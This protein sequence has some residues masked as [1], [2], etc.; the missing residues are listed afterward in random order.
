MYKTAL[1][2]LTAPSSARTKERQSDKNKR[3]YVNPFSEALHRTVPDYKTLG[4]FVAEPC[5][6]NKPCLFIP[7]TGK[8]IDII[9]ELKRR[10]IDFS[11]QAHLWDTNTQFP[12][13]LDLKYFED[14]DYAPL[15]PEKMIS[16][17]K[18]VPPQVLRFYKD[19]VL[20][21]YVTDISFDSKTRLYS[22]RFK[23]G[24]TTN[25]SPLFVLFPFDDPMYFVDRIERAFQLRRLEESW[26]RYWLFIS[27]VPREDIQILTPQERSRF[28]S[29]STK[30]PKFKGFKKDGE[31][32]QF[33]LKILDEIDSQMQI[34][35]NSIIFNMR[36]LTN[37]TLYR[38]LSLPLPRLPGSLQE[39][40]HP[41]VEG[42][43]KMTD[44]IKVI[45]NIHLFTNDWFVNAAPIIVS[46][47]LDISSSCLFNTICPQ[48]LPLEQWQRHHRNYEK[49]MISKARL[50]FVSQL[51]TVIFDVIRNIKP[52]YSLTEFNK[53]IYLESPLGRFVGLC[54]QIIQ[55]H[56][57]DFIENSISCFKENIKEKNPEEVTVVDYKF[58]KNSFPDMNDHPNPM[59]V[60]NLEVVDGQVQFN[61]PIEY[62]TNAFNE[63][64]EYCI[65][66]FEDFQKIE[67]SVLKAM[68]WNPVPV[69]VLPDM[70]SPLVVDLKN[71][72][73]EMIDESTKHMTEYIEKLS[74]FDDILTVSADDFAARLK[75]SEDDLDKVKAA[76]A[77]VQKQQ[78]G[79][80]ID[81]PFKT[82]I[83]LFEV[84]LSQ[85][86][87]T[88]YQKLYER[89]L[90]LLHLLLSVSH[91]KMK[92][93]QKTYD[94]M[95]QR[96]LEEPK[97]IEALVAQNEFID[98]LNRSLL[99]L[100]DQFAEVQL[101]LDTVE[102]MF[103]SIPDDQDN[104]RWELIGYEKK[105]LSKSS[106]VIQS[107][108]VAEEQLQKALQCDKMMLSSQITSIVSAIAGVFQFNDV[109]QHI[110][111][112]ARV[113]GIQTKLD[114]AIEKAELYN[115]REKLC[116]FEQSDY[117][118]LKSQL[119]QFTPY[120]IFWEAISSWKVSSE[121][122]TNLPL[123]QLD[124]SDVESQFSFIAQQLVQSSRVITDK[125]IL[126][127]AQAT[128]AEMDAFKKFLPI[129]G[130]M[131]NPGMTEKHW[132]QLSELVGADITLTETMTLQ[133]TIEMNL[134]EHVTNALE[135]SNAA[136]NEHSIK[137]SLQRV[138]DCWA[139]AN[140][141]IHNY[142]ETSWLILGSVEEIIN[143]IDENLITL[144][145]INF[146][147]YKAPFEEEVAMWTS[148]LQLT[149]RVIEKWLECQA[150]Y[151]YL[152]PIFSSKDICHQLPHEG[153][154]FQRVSEEWNT[155]L[156][157]CQEDPNAFK[158]CNDKDLL[159]LFKKMLVELESIERALIE[160]LETKRTAFPRF[161]FLSNEELLKILSQ[162]T[163]PSAVQPY[164]KRCFENIGSITFK[165]NDF[166]TEMTSVEGEL[167]PFV[168][169]TQLTGS[170]EH[171]MLGVEAEMRNTLEKV[172][173]R[174]VEQ[175]STKQRTE[176]IYE[177]PAQIVIAVFQIMWT[178][179][180]ESAIKAGKLSELYGIIH[181][182]L[183]DLAKMTQLDS[184]SEINR[185][186]ISSCI[187]M[188]MHNRDIV[189][190]LD[191]QNVSDIRQ[192]EWISQLRQYFVNG[193][194]V[195]RMVNAE[196]NY[197]YEYLGST[198]RLVITPL[199]DRCYLTLLTALDM[200]LGGAPQGPAGTGK[201]ETTKDLAKVVA[202][203]CVV[204][205]CSEGLDYLQMGTFF[206]GLSSCG[207]WACFDE[208]NRIDIEVLSVI[209]QQI[210]TIQA[211]IQQH[212]HHFSF[213]GREVRLN[214][215]CAI[216]I[217]MNP[218]YA[219]RAE[220]PDNLKA[221]FR[222]VAM[223]VPNYTMIAEIMLYS[224]GFETAKSLAVKITTTFR[225]SSEQLSSQS[226]YDFGMRAVKTVINT[227]GNLLMREKEL[228]EQLIILRSLK[229]VNV[230][231]FTRQDLPL[232]NN[233][234][235]DLFPSVEEKELDY[236][237]LV[238]SIQ[239]V[240]EKKKLK[241]T[242]I[243][244]AI[245]LYETINVR[246]GV[247]LVGP[248][249]CGK[250]QTYE[251]LAGAL[252]KLHNEKNSGYYPVQYAVMN[253]KSITLGQLYGDFDPHSHD[254]T[255]GLLADA[256]RF[257]SA[258]PPPFNHWIVLDGPVDA[259][260]IENMNT[261]LDDNKK[262]CLAS[263]EV[264]PLTPRMRMFFEVEDL[265]VA[266]PA[267]V[268]RCGMVYIENKKHDYE[269]LL[270]SWILHQGEKGP[271]LEPQLR[272]FLK[273]VM[274]P[275][276][277]DLSSNFR[278]SLPYHEYSYF[279]NFLSLVRSIIKPEKDV[280]TI[281]QVLIFSLVWS[282]GAITNGQD[283]PKFDANTKEILT[284]ANYSFPE[285]ETLFDYCVKGGEWI[286][287]SE[288]TDKPADNSQGS[289]MIVPTTETTRHS[290]VINTLVMNGIAV[291]VSGVTGSGKTVTLSKYIESQPTL[292][293]NPMTFSAQ[294]TANGI[295]DLL[296]AKFDRRS[297]G[298]FGPPID[299][300][301]IIFVDDINMPRKEK[302]GAQPPIELLRQLLC[303][304]GWYDRKKRT[305]K[306]FVDVQMICS[307]RSPEG[308]EQTPTGRF[309]RFF[310][311]IV[312]PEI[313]D[314]SM[315][316]IFQAILSNHLSAVQDI[317][318]S[319][320]SASL[321]V[322]NTVCKNLLPTPARVHYTF[323]LRDIS[324]VIRS[325]TSLHSSQASDKNHVLR[326]WYHESI[327]VY[328]DRLIN[329]ENREWFMELLNRVLNDT[330]KVS[331]SELSSVEPV[332][333]ADFGIDDSKKY[334]QI[335][336]LE[337]FTKVCQNNLDDYNSSSPV[338]L[339]IVLFSEAIQH[340][341]RICRIIREPGRNGLL[342][343][344]GGSGRQSLTKLASFIQ[345]VHLFQPQVNTAYGR[346]EWRNDLKQLLM[347]C[348]L[349]KKETV[350]LISESQLVDE[351]FFEDINC[352]LNSGDPPSLFDDDDMEK[353]ISGTTPLAKTLGIVPTRASIYSLF[354][355]QVKRY[356]HVIIALS[357][358]GTSFRRRVRMFPSL[359]SCC[360]IDWFASWPQEALQN[361]ATRTIG[362][363]FSVFCAAAHSI[364]NTYCTKFFE[365]MK[366]TNYVTPS[367]FLSFLN[368]TTSIGSR[369]NTKLETTASTIKKGLQKM[370]EAGEEIVVL[371]KNIRELQPVLKVKKE[372][373]MKML[374][375]LAVDKEKANEIRDHVAK[376]T[377]EAEQQSELAQKLASEA[378]ADLD[379]VLPKVEAALKALDTLDR[380]QVAVL[381][382]V[383]VETI[384]MKL[385][386]Q[387]LCIVFDEPPKKVQ[388]GISY[389]EPARVIMA[390]PRFLM[391]VREWTDQ[392]KDKIPPEKM[393]K[394]QPVIEHPEFKP[395]IMQTKNSAAA[396]LCMWIHA[397]KLYNDVNIDVEPK[398]K[399]LA[400]AEA[401][402]A[403]ALKAVE[404]SKAKLAEIEKGVQE[405]TD[406]HNAAEAELRELKDKKK[407]CKIRLERAGIL[408]TSLENEKE[409]WQRLLVE[410]DAQKKTING[411]V[412]IAAASI[413]YLGPFTSDFRKLIIQ[414]WA[415]KL[416]EYGFNR[417]PNGNITKIM[418]DPLTILQWHLKSLP[419]DDLSIENAIILTECRRWPLIIDPQNQAVTFIRNIES[420]LLVLR[421]KD[422]NFVRSLENAV[423]FGRAVL[424][425]GIDEDL[426]PSL[427]PILMIS[428]RDKAI[429]IKLEHQVTY[430]VNFKL[431]L[432]TN[433]PNPSFSPENL[434]KVTLINFTITQTA[435]GD[436]L[437]ALV[438]AKEKPNLEKEKESLVVNNATMKSQMLEIQA[439]ILKLLQESSGDILDDVVLIDTLAESNKTSKVLSESMVQSE[440]TERM[441]DASRREY[442]PVARRGS[443]LYF[444][445]IDLR[446]VAP[447]Y[448]YSLSWYC[449][450]VSK[451]ISAAPH[452]A[453]LEERLNNLIDYITLKVFKNVSNSLFAKHQLMFAFLISARVGIDMGSISEAEWKFLL[454]GTADST[455][456]P[457]PNKIPDHI[458]DATWGELF[459]LSQ[460][461]MFQGFNDYVA[462]NWSEISNVKD[463][464]TA[465]VGGGYQQK[466][467]LFRRLC[468]ARCLMPDTLV[469]GFTKMISESLSDEYLVIEPGN[470]T[471]AFADA[472]PLTPIIFILS[473][474]T[475]PAQDVQNYASQNGALERL[476]SLS[477]GQGQGEKAAE[478]IE[479]GRVE[480]FWVLLQNCH[481]ATSWMPKLEEILQNL[482]EVHADFRLLL[483][484]MPT[485][486]FPAS[487]LQSG[488]KVTTEAPQGLKATLTQLFSS[489]GQK[490]LK[491]CSR[492]AEFK[493]MFYSLCFF[494]AVVLGRRKYGPLGW[495]CVYDWTKG[496][497]DISRKQLNL[498][499]SQKGDIPFKTLGFLVGEINYGGRVTDDW[500]RRT[501]L[502]LVQDFY[503]EEVLQQGHDI[504]P[505]YKT[506]A[507]SN[508][509]EYLD[510]I[511]TY[512][513][514]D[515]PELFG[516]HPNAD[517]NLK[518]LT[519]FTI[520]SDILSTRPRGSGSGGANNALVAL[521][522]TLLKKVPEP[523]DMHV[524]QEKFPSI[525]EESMNT[526]LQQEAVRYNELLRVV[527]A[528]LKALLKAM[529]GLIV[530]SNDLEDMATAL[531][532]NLVPPNWAAVAYPS[533]KPLNSWMN[534]LND[535][536]KFLKD[537]IESGQ[538]HVFWISGFFFPQAFLTG[539]KQ[540]F[541]RKYKV[542]I[543][544]VAFDF[545]VLDKGPHKIVE[546]PSDGVYI[547][548]LFLEAAGFDI[549]EG[550]LV[551]AQP[552]QLTQ[553]MPVIWLKPVQNRQNP[554]SGIYSCPVYKI[555]TRQGV[556]T[557]TG[558]SSNFVLT[559]EL[560]TDV[561]ES[562]WIKRGVALLCSLS[563]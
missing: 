426:D 153:V 232:F 91:S 117:S 296:D 142:K 533:L 419:R 75:D 474:G 345:G 477:L 210:A 375:Q 308:P 367:T 466:L 531:D 60:I 520:L 355:S 103:V 207:A 196:F 348:G 88:L 29:I 347:G 394:L 441:I 275:V 73:K 174:S 12:S 318:D 38:G 89:R 132:Q 396:A 19:A 495:N 465:E 263:S 414:E 314:E 551:D 418:G 327:R 386:A 486:A 39:I 276:L 392:N 451:L 368:L 548:G 22:V 381:R 333:Y 116:N 356:L 472:G 302:Y 511:A 435:L 279:N 200:Q 58:V 500:D 543:D 2:S 205:N 412:L 390:D 306:K 397:L 373:V 555:G 90:A 72:F 259:L 224:F 148:G 179:A 78:K 115:M 514:Q 527:K 297:A 487:I 137:N 285:S 448:Q 284:K 228:S 558:H 258:E 271:V 86:R 93:I 33:S 43:A 187:V 286:N 557:T 262:L 299:H 460:L 92:E 362:D 277:E 31:K 320:I 523:L 538:P 23:D 304:E 266:S 358:I 127:I 208:F 53:N 496:D 157:K 388:G 184:L 501:L 404:E 530:F 395:E 433:N 64:V 105:I 149:L 129:F 223:M 522:N 79:L 535:R 13:F 450:L 163:H 218:G 349:G 247:M 444:C 521:A 425:E 48:A 69:Y 545:Q 446:H 30:L 94:E 354:I 311:Q 313:S 42:I 401:N 536:I 483:T 189:H 409:S 133:N 87:K 468:V 509:P 243:P 549:N 155:K 359:V 25:I 432:V 411:D 525:Y 125:E 442:E 467:N 321:E 225:L 36:I 427:D 54:N 478:M 436:Q 154:K 198:N 212:R 249:G 74:V 134:H 241:D 211:A 407:K 342:L 532:Q 452:S 181:N 503:R 143:L 104:L 552:R 350:F 120:K 484:S 471:Q 20:L 236:T 326:I 361:V 47:C 146:S 329:N 8:P 294:T 24:R 268:S 491:E 81:F 139:G 464:L 473:S 222:P 128:R 379:Q 563:R 561:E 260:W 343:G 462:D 256:V 357:P 195:I 46:W 289:E 489:Y 152:A 476:R 377:Q 312:F 469:N 220:L 528:T 319:I 273:D 517:L 431:Y 44:K 40:P 141:D 455:D 71:A 267:T 461:D 328:H 161:Y 70:E 109:D 300:R 166:V 213:E 82:N 192:F 145:A 246:H 341:C 178:S 270:H 175:Y 239:A 494:H 99:E 539:T 542:P 544:E 112:V 387:A 556:L 406:K 238:A 215:T 6:I 177:W 61:P 77:E 507:P 57:V 360:T 546:P 122:W 138:A 508:L 7:Y 529:K 119:E 26:F 253:P 391:R 80:H 110:S 506:P 562:F 216:F 282:V 250:T 183:L 227:A 280:S 516:L 547:H 415:A 106:E 209:A 498:F 186:T 526:V 518:Q 481:L 325:I 98:N 76:I 550:K 159:K 403:A 389:W 203:Q 147:Q 463:W 378:Q 459:N 515:T 385:I 453:V 151:L 261:V 497:L 165:G 190:N 164:L 371:E 107:L 351:S 295:Q 493:S 513:V 309:L 554:E 221:L 534:D 316:R 27:K 331:H 158:F 214:P 449:E 400:E 430:N 456:E 97:T 182:Q 59:F 417:T 439:K 95:W 131:L 429:Q 421:P 291:L 560:P 505:G 244:K 4:I 171:W 18:D 197:G 315:K 124:A 290:W 541:A 338:P 278:L 380:N 51:S 201:T 305:F 193:G 235:S 352:L 229:D 204:F 540:N 445:I 65:T 479:N 317:I 457:P 485:D 3:K 307:M 188:E 340:L 490:A 402:K 168:R 230:P 111:Y 310:H 101:Y 363:E 167:V 492:E 172:L 37:P 55:S 21:E 162:T 5:Q 510:E 330:F 123:S 292:I 118:Q 372:E 52:P 413:A 475:D 303:Q 423:S 169:P 85:V 519:S 11:R 233:I 185:T 96:L 170:V 434:A 84:D 121:K 240:C 202:K 176:W 242:L 283:R 32:Y 254:Y 136:T 524:I 156:K 364:V 447:M 234:I 102:D 383:S 217:T 405:L 482:K 559:I 335:T 56:L 537:W 108:K 374:E 420:D 408:T 336:D 344:V 410:L 9:A 16:L 144:Q 28:L 288:L 199:T 66:S 160:Y 512:P 324:Q 438:V 424:V 337:K 416:E 126:G 100:K 334:Q 339:D 323:N 226:H 173:E 265:K 14:T 382:N 140:L 293:N 251:C 366:R 35:T 257:A 458:S 322:Y 443:L 49:A 255:D 68:M 17:L 369:L 365:E 206:T 488:S 480:G 237:K 231:K 353:I 376:A 454:T 370:V 398:R 301:A 150:K 264:I 393:K 67:T 245:E 553:E 399:K 180:V 248:A 15:Q 63:E 384:S 440:E 281:D 130:I 41:E 10:G 252:T 422:K 135:I 470:I 298:I 219:G 269:S 50:K 62:F 272:R 114:E 346:A 499:L 274:V 34:V 504:A 437:L 45:Q 428:S 1:S 502:T 332:V 113:R 194:A 287:W 83:G 191:K